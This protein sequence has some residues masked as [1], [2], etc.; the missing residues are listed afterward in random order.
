MT[1]KLPGRGRNRDGVV[2]RFSR[3]L[4]RWLGG[5]IAVRWFW[6]RSGVGSWGRGARSELGLSFFSLARPNLLKHPTQQ[7]KQHRTASSRTCAACGSSATRRASE[8]SSRGGREGGN[9][10]LETFAETRSCA[11]GSRQACCLLF[12]DDRRSHTDCYGLLSHLTSG[13]S[14][15]IEACRSQIF[16]EGD[17]SVSPHNPP[18]STI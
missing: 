18:F 4:V 14:E 16:E 11:T 6:G 5:C 2:A 12:L 15:R 9:V 1:L 7:K 10:C 8:P 3:E 17:R 13:P